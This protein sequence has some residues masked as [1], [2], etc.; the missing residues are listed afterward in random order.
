M[1]DFNLSISLILYSHI[2]FR[3]NLIMEVF[4]HDIQ[5]YIWKTYFSKFI[6]KEIINSFDFVWRNPSD[7]LVDICKDVGTV[8]QGH[9]ELEEMIEDHNMEYWHGCVNGHCPNCDDYGFPCTNLAVYGFN[10]DKLDC[11]WKANFV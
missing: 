5:W 6:V 4:P 11:L 8:Q 2:T 3:E 10:N 1:C 9:T 7:R